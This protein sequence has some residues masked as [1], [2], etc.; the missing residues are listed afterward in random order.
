MAVTAKPIEILKD[1]KKRKIRIWIEDGELRYQ[2]PKGAMSPE[3]IQRLQAVKEGVHGVLEKSGL[4][5][6]RDSQSIH[7][8]DFRISG[9]NL[10]LASLQNGPEPAAYC[11]YTITS[12][13]ATLS[14]FLVNI[15][16]LDTE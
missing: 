11:V 10:T 5:Q 7:G 13:F 16:Y 4:V 14:F 12:G 6:Y 1:L 15:R 3:L 9:S 8:R 2:A